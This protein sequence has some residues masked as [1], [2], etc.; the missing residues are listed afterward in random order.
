MCTDSDHHYSHE[1]NHLLKRSIGLAIPTDFPLYLNQHPHSLLLGNWDPADLPA[2]TPLASPSSSSSQ[3]VPRSTKDPHN[4]ATG[5]CYSSCLGPGLHVC[6]AHPLTYLWQNRP[7]PMSKAAHPP[8][9]ALAL[10]TAS[11]DLATLC[12]QGVFVPHCISGSST[13]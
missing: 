9:H 3:L 12:W 8:W 7:Q 11:A 13:L 5:T 2:P 4:R 10:L 1:P 6:T